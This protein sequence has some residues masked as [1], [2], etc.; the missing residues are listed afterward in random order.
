MDDCIV[1]VLLLTFADCGSTYVETVD[2]RASLVSTVDIVYDANELIPV[3]GK[4]DTKF[5]LRFVNVNALFDQDFTLPV[6]NAT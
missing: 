2:L 5:P 3:I 6:A 4:L 1:Y